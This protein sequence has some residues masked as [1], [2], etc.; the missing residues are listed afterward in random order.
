M[1]LKKTRKNGIKRESDKK[2]Q[3]RWEKKARTI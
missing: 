1:K 2:A 3:K